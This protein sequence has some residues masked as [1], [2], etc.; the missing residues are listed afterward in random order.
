MKRMT[1]IPVVAG[2]LLLTIAIPTVSANVL[3]FGQ[4][5]DSESFNAL[6]QQTELLYGGS[7]ESAAKTPAADDYYSCSVEG[8]Y[9]A[10]A[11]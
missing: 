4:T 8:Q 1:W 3:G 11:Y 10:N 6:V 2:A 5:T 7:D 9:G